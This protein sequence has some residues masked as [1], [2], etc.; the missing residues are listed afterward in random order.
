MA[1][2]HLL[3]VDGDQQRAFI[4]LLTDALRPAIALDLSSTCHELR[5]VAAGHTE[6]KRRHGAAKRLCYQVRMSPVEVSE[7]KELLWYGQGLTA[8]HLTTLNMLIK[9]H[10]LP[11]LETLNLSINRFGVEGMQAMC[12]ELGH[13]SLPQ[14]RA[15]DLTGNVFGPAGAAAFAGTLYRGALPRLEV[16]KL[17][18]NNIG[19]EGLAALAPP[20]RG[21]HELKELHLFSNA[22]GNEGVELLLANLGAQQL[23]QLKTLNLTDNRIGD[24]CRAMLLAALGAADD[25]DDD[26]C[27][28]PPLEVL[29]IGKTT[30]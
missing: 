22:I 24:A 25:A 27:S 12:Q 2:C 1:E 20:L 18:R 6:L 19:D 4:D 5:A 9:T 7:A 21:L 13:G 11:R 16:L 26:G 29:R 8:G 3:R 28:L 15:L 23:K 17:G 10:A 30:G 14:L